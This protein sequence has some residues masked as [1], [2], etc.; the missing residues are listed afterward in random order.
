MSVSQDNTGDVNPEAKDRLQETVVGQVTDPAEEFDTP[1]EVPDAHDD[2]D[3]ALQ[4]GKD[5]ADGKGD[6]EVPEGDFQGYADPSADHKE[7]S[8]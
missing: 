1:T 2:V 7:D 4:D 3:V 6:E 5:T 8:N